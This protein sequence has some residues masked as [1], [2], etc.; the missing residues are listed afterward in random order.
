MA[1]GLNSKDGKA[2]MMYVGEV[3]WHGLGTALARPATAAEAIKAAGLDW[4]VAKTPVHLKNGRRYSLIQ[5]RFAVIRK[6]LKPSEVVP[7]GFVGKGYTPLQNRD[8][9]AW[10]DPIVGKDA[11]VYHTAGAL[12]DGERVW[13]LAKLPGE[14][15][16]AGDDIAEKYL[17]LSNSHDGQSSV[18]VKF[19][20]IRVVC[21]NTLTMA[22]S[23]GK[24]IR[25]SHTSSLPDRLQ[26]A[27]R[28]LGI[29]KERFE[30]IEKD[31]QALAAVQMT[32]GRL[33]DY[34]ARVFP[35][36]EDKNDERARRRIERTRTESAKLFEAGSG[37]QAPGVR[38]TL[39]AAYNGVTEFVDYYSK[40]L[41]RGGRLDSVWFGA[42]YHAKAKA[43][44][45]AN[46]CATDWNN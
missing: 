36:P 3:P 33:P 4:D 24:G 11:A 38:G 21:Q 46:E 6:D 14:I 22:L 30:D 17:L 20:P 13:V 25:I 19:T 9:F 37:N 43:F 29:I 26:L 12:G 18:Q 28:N 42:G 35:D 10:F 27:E 2:S 40:A 32:N 5:N 34:L 15:R 1:H 41:W 23:S 31:F 8:A 39:W 44:R 45:V 16:V 7:L